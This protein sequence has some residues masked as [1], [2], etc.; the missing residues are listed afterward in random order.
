MYLRTPDSLL[1]IQILQLKY[2]PLNRP[3]PDLDHVLG[4]MPPEFFF[5]ALSAAMTMEIIPLCQCQWPMIVPIHTASNAGLAAPMPVPTL[6]PFSAH[7]CT[8]INLK[9]RTWQE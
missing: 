9:D 3:C 7:T 4:E 8:I 6:F 2:L 1:L 5:P